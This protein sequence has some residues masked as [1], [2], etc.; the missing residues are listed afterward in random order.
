MPPTV[1]VVITNT[2]AHLCNRG[3]LQATF[4]RDGAGE[5]CVEASFDSIGC[6]DKVQPFGESL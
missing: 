3:A 1:E 6:R 2:A 5:A 4:D